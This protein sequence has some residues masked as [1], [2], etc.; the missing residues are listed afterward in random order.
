MRFHFKNIF[1]NL[2]L[3]G[4]LALSTTP[5]WAYALQDSYIPPEVAFAQD[6]SQHVQLT[7]QFNLNTMNLGE[8]KSIPGLSEDIALKIMRN[9]PF[10]DI[11]DF[12]RRMPAVSGK[13][14]NLWIR[15]IQPRLLFK[16]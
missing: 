1:F 11:Q 9:R 8:L 4:F 10:T 13:Q 5:G 3:C 7:E 6:L 16:Q 14:L 2:L 12:Y 15:Q